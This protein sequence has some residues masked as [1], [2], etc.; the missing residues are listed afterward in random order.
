MTIR[1]AIDHCVEQNLLW[2][3][4]YGAK[5]AW[6]STEKDC[7]KEGILFKELEEFETSPFDPARS[8][9]GNQ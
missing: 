1:Q 9:E 2:R 3:S 4:L 6:E 8:E 7:G 5:Q